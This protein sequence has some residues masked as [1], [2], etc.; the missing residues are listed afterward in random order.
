ME[1]VEGEDAAHSDTRVLNEPEFP[2]CYRLHRVKDVMERNSVSIEEVISELAITLQLYTLSPLPCSVC[3]TAWSPG[4]VC[5]IATVAW[6]GQSGLGG[7]HRHHRHCRGTL[8][9]LYYLPNLAE[10]L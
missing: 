9:N 4:M 6:R 1:E 10:V 7:R 8:W 2:F 3:C 5:P